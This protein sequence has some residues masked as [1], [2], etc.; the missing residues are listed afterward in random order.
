MSFFKENKLNI[1]NSTAGMIAWV[2]ISL[3]NFCFS[4]I[5]E[6]DFTF[7]PIKFLLIPFIILFSGFLAIKYKIFK[8]IISEKKLKMF[9]HIVFTSI[10]GLYGTYVCITQPESYNGF[11]VLFTYTIGLVY[12]N[13]V[14]G[15]KGTI[16]N[17]ILFF[18]VFYVFMKILNI[19]FGKDEMIL[20]YFFG[21]SGL[22][23]GFLNENTIIKNKNL[24]KRN[25]SIKGLLENL[26]QG[27]MIIDKKGIIQ[28]GATQITRVFF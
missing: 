27:F 4:V 11:S 1:I 26:G 6:T 8:K 5:F 16:L 21:F 7:S 9:T 20:I 12:W 14:L 19:N 22:I 3:S 18:L 13:G 10:N 24:A 28:K 23:F 15:F 17:S 2:F 25:E